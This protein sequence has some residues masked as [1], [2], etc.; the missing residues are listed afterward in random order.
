[1]ADEAKPNA[2][3]HA[4]KIAWLSKLDGLILREIH[5]SN[6]PYEGYSEDD[7]QK[8]LVV[9]FPYCD[10]VY[11]YY[12]QAQIDKENNEID[13]YDQNITMY[14]EALSK[15]QAYFIRTHRTTPHR[16]RF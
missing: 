4:A 10:D 14:D 13:H 5:M 16:F 2:H 6:E 15:Y 7:Q 3:S 12:I 11:S 9:P 8:E 1:M